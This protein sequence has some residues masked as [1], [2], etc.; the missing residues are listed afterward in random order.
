MP[1]P[2]RTTSTKR[3]GSPRH[4]T[5][6]ITTV[7]S[8]S[9]AW[10]GVGATGPR[11]DRDPSLYS[12]VGRGPGRGGNEGG[13][14]P[15]PWA[16]LLDATR[17]NPKASATTFIKENLNVAKRFVGDRLTTLRPPSIDPRQ[18]HP[19]PGWLADGNLDLHPSGRSA[20]ELADPHPVCFRRR[21]RSVEA[22]R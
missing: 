14:H 17:L 12:D 20:T 16:S 11:R 1:S 10:F 21:A 3:T 18:H 7:F 15:N 4:S 8:F 19:G 13:G 6:L 5:S 2:G 9:T 22:L